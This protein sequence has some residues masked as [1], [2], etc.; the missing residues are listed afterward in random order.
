MFLPEGEIFLYGIV[1]QLFI[2]PSLASAKSFFLLFLEQLKVKLV[3]LLVSWFSF[4]QKQ[5]T[6][7]KS[8]GGYSVVTANQFCIT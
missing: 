2:Y 8:D 4:Y 5:T 1:N 3:Q 7:I 6:D